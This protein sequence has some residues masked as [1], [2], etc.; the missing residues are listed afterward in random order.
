MT[1]VASGTLAGRPRPILGGADIPHH[2]EGAPG[3]PVCANFLIQEDHAS[4]HV[5]GECIGLVRSQ[6]PG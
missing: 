6:V 3:N 4:C 5:Q 1:R 2:A